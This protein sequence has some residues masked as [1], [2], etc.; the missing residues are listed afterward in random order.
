MKLLGAGA[1]GKVYQGY[2][3]ADRLKVAVKELRREG[4]GWRNNEADLKRE[5]K[6]L[7]KVQHP[8]V[9][10]VYDFY[11]DPEAKRC[12]MVC[13]F[14]K[15]GDLFD[16]VVSRKSKQG[17]IP[18]NELEARSI[19]YVVMK[20][21]EYIHRYDIVHRDIK[22]ENLLLVADVD[23]P[24]IKIADF[25]FADKETQIKPG[26][27]GTAG[28]MAPEILQIKPYGKKADV[29]SLGVVVYIL[30]AGFAPTWRQGQNQKAINEAV[31][32]NEFDWSAR[33][34]SMV[35]PEVMDLIRR[36]MEPD[37]NNRPTVTEALKHPWMMKAPQEIAARPLD[38]T[39][40][41]LRR[42]NAKRKLMKHV[43][44]VMAANK[45]KRALGAFGKSQNSTSP[46][47][48]PGADDFI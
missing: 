26:I 18:Y 45:F 37:P 42:F 3:L 43:R 15:G 16:T 8:N 27:C 13:E 35:S 19:I 31:L 48:P 4:E 47:T 23:T 20:A 33:I 6:V 9:I 36:L 32:N 12:Y 22:P 1:F 41:A 21:V 24:T 39:M 28:Y 38:E 40:K 2:R 14:M 5:V 30:L 34:W 25:G 46:P 29:F 10:K 44:G 17:T 11:V 7:Q